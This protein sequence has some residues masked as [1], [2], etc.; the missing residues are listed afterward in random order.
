MLSVLL[1]ARCHGQACLAV[2]LQFTGDDAFGPSFSES[3]EVGNVAI[4]AALARRD[5]VHDLALRCVD[6]ANAKFSGSQAK[7]GVFVAV[8]KPGIKTA[9][10]FEQRLSDQQATAG[11]ARVVALHIHGWMV[12]IESKKDMPRVLLFREGHSRMPD[13]TGVD[14][15][16]GRKELLVANNANLRRLG[17]HFE[18]CFQPARLDHR[19]VIQKQKVLTAC[20]P[21]ASITTASKEEVS[22]IA[23]VTNPWLQ[24]LQVLPAAIR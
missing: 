19:I 18:H 7:V 14:G 23:D 17:Q 5:V 24:R 4:K 22:R 6:N 15:I 20:R 13:K 1:H 2:A 11:N 9:Q 3:Q 21:G 10:P 12:G 8:L 16:G